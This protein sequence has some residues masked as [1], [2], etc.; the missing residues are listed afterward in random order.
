MNAKIKYITTLALSALIL[1]GFTVGFWLKGSDSFS[2]S[3]RRVL[4]QFPALNADTLLSGDFVSDFETYMLD[5]FP[6]RDG[7]RT[8]KAISELF[9]FARLDNNDVFLSNGYISKL[10]YPLRAD[11]LERVKNKFAS[12]YD[13]YLKDANTNVYLSIIPD[14]NMFLAEQNGYLGLDYEAFIETVK[15]NTSFAEYIDIT[16]LLSIEDYYYTDTH[17]QQNLILDV[18]DRLTS[19]MGSYVPSTNYIEHTVQDG[20]Y[21]VYH[22]QAALPLPPDDITYLTNDILDNCI[23]TVYDNYGKPQ[24]SSIYNMD[25][26]NSYDPYEMYLS[27]AVT[28]VEIENPAAE[29]DKELVI[30]RDSFGSSI[31]PLLVSGYSKVTLVDLRYMGEAALPYYVNFENADVLF[32]YSTLVLNNASF[33]D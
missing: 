32:L 16:D 10:E 15:N 23:V 7:F 31:A 13:K 6:M 24:P 9:G 17:W 22:G 20:F 5:Q 27:G 25:K 28:L 26:L 8:V 29:S 14:K 4:A 33:R 19:A 11:S 30:F 18:A 21:G 12:V 3:E 1:F 2:E